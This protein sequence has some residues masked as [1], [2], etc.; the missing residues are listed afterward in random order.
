MLTGLDRELRLASRAK[1][2]AGIRAESEA[3]DRRVLAEAVGLLP[4][5]DRPPLS[6]LRVE[7]LRGKNCEALTRHTDATIRIDR[8]SGTWREAL[9]GKVVRLASVIA[10]ESCHLRGCREESIAFGA[11]LLFLRSVP[12]ADPGWVRLV[13]RMAAQARAREAQDV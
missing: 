13:K 4:E 10:H 8:T 1:C 6:A 12:D 5:G 2:L 9:A 7:R 11:E 3:R